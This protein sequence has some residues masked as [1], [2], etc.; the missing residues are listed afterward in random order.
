MLTVNGMIQPWNGLYTWL[1]PL[2]MW[3]VELGL[4]L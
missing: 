3:N 2:L 1:S 4:L